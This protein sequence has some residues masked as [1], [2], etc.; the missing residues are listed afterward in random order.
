MKLM[1]IALKFKKGN[2]SINWSIKNGISVHRLIK[3]NTVSIV[4]PDF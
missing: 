1:A 4:C 3:M 2:L